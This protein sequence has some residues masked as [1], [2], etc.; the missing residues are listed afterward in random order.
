M[1]KATEKRLPISFFIFQ[2]ENIAHQKYAVSRKKAS[3]FQ[4]MPF[5]GGNEGASVGR[6]HRLLV[7]LKI[8][9]C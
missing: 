6:G 3:A 2:K 9:P 8:H 4:Q 7:T 5:F 1:E